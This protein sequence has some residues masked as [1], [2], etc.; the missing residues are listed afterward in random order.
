MKEVDFRKPPDEP[1][2]AAVEQPAPTPTGNKIAWEGTVR[3]EAGARVAGADVYA[4]VSFHGGMRMQDTIQAVQ[5]DQEVWGMRWW[6]RDSFSAAISWY[7]R[8]AIRQS[9]SR[10]R[11]R[12]RRWHW[13]S[14]SAA[15]RWMS[16][17]RDGKPL[18]NA[19]V[20]LTRQPHR[21]TTAFM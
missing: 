6:W 20:R 13:C 14:R 7:T 11:L 19:S 21:S 1:A 15:G 8:L 18:A 5:S 9:S 17:Q 10:C 3:D 12:G 16:V 4:I 2:P